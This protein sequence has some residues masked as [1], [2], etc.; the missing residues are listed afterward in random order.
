MH[1]ELRGVVSYLLDWRRL[2][3]VRVAV[4]QD[5]VPVVRRPVGAQGVVPLAR[6]CGAGHAPAQVAGACLSGDG[7]APAAT[8]P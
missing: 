7:H 3:F 4:G 8:S 2:S 6:L 5:P 1:A